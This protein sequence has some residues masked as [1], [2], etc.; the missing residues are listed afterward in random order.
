MKQACHSDTAR[1]RAALSLCP[2]PAE[3]SNLRALEGAKGM[4][5]L[6]WRY[7]VLEEARAAFEATYAPTGAWAQLFARADGYR[8]TEL[9]RAEDGSY[10]T[11]DIWRSRA[12]FDAFLAAH[13]DDY[14]AL[15]R[16]DRR[17]D[18]LRAPDR[19]I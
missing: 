14:E 19:R 2:G 16:C 12:D 17:L 11:L 3:R 4:I 6:V 1:A 18:R 15:D 9:F 13:R 5:A 8:G 10:L 7:E